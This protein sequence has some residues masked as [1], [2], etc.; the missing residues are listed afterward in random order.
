MRPR[1]SHDA[2]AGLPRPPHWN[3]D[4]ECRDSLNPDIWFAAGND[5]AA[6]A[7]LRQAKKVCGRCPVRSACLHAALQ[8]GETSGVWG[9]LDT[10]E[11]KRLVLLPPAREPETVQARPDGAQEEHAPA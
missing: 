11:R 2:P 10:D 6:V 1:S 8:R 7:D 3:D 9:G 4:A 5:P